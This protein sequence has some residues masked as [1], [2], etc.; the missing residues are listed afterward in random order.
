[1]IHTPKT[2]AVYEIAPKN[3]YNIHQEIKAVAKYMGFE[4]LYPVDTEQ[5][6]NGRYWFLDDEKNSI[7]DA[8]DVSVDINDPNKWVTD[9][10]PMAKNLAEVHAK[11]TLVRKIWPDEKEIS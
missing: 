6:A 9:D 5:P 4:L 7:G 2:T 11:C 10:L 8:I 3:I 1:M